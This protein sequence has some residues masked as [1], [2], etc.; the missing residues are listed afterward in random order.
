[1]VLTAQQ[2]GALWILA[3]GPREVTAEAISQAYVESGFDTNAES[4][5]HNK[6]LWQIGPNAPASMFNPFEN[7]KAAV[8]KWRSGGNTFVTAWT[9]FQ[10]PGTE[11]KRL[12]YLPRAKFAASR[13]VNLSGPQLQ[14]MLGP[15]TINAVGGIPGLDKIIPEIPLPDIP[16][17]FGW[18]D[19]Q[20]PDPGDV[21]P[22]PQDFVGALADIA[23][24]FG[25][26]AEL[27]RGFF[28][29]VTKWSEK[30]TDIETW[31][32]AGKIFIGFMLLYIGTKRLFTISTGGN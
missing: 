2:V 16:N 6:G 14:T 7:A 31:K 20:I 13:I 24:S 4:S 17:P 22:S 3:G 30:I 12:A 18:L 19:D 27:L 28:E 9:N 23:G 29:F 11:A 8:G 32:D 21:V 25:N 5:T 26:I 1:M 10:G 15:R